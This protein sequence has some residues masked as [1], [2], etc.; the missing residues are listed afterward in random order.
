MSKKPWN[1]EALKKRGPN[2]D[3]PLS[4]AVLRYREHMEQEHD[5]APEDYSNNVLGWH[6]KTIR[7]VKLFRLI[8]KLRHLS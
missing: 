6:K 8:K 3:Y 5:A 2:K 4:T 1:Y 7:H